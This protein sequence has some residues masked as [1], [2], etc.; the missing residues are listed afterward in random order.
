[1]LIQVKRKTDGKIFSSDM[2]NE[3][4]DCILS[5][6]FCTSYTQVTVQEENEDGTK[7]EKSDVICPPIGTESN[8]VDL[9]ACQGD[10]EGE[11]LTPPTKQGKD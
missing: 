1:M 2:S 9:I 8:W 10:L 7:F 5:I 11:F 6:G 4:K 3:N